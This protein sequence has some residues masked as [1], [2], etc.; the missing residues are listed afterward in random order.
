MNMEATNNAFPTPAP[1]IDL[2]PDS[3]RD[4][5]GNVHGGV[6]DDH[7]PVSITRADAG[8]DHGPGYIADGGTT[9]NSMPRLS[10]T[11]DI[12]AP[13]WDMEG[14]WITIM[15]NGVEVGRVQ[16]DYF[17][18]WSYQPDTALSLGEHHF[19]A[20]LTDYPA[21][22]GESPESDSY[23]LN[24]QSAPAAATSSVLEAGEQHASAPQATFGFYVTG[25]NGILFGG[26]TISSLH[27]AVRGIGEPGSWVT[28]MDGSQEV[29][30][31][32]VGADGRWA[33]SVDLGEGAHHLSAVAST[34]ETS[35]A[36]D[37]N[38]NLSLKVMAIGDDFG[39]THAHGYQIA[40]GTHVT[41][42]LHYS[43]QALFGRTHAD[44]QVVVKDGDRV[45]GTVQADHDGRWNLEY[46][47]D[48]VTGVHHLSAE[49]VGTSEAF[50]F[51]V[52]YSPATT[53]Q[54][55]TQPLALNDV[56]SGS[57]GELFAADPTDNNAT[58]HL[59][60]VHAAPADSMATS[61]VSI[62]LH[63]AS[64]LNTHLVLPHDHVH[65]VM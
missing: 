1:A 47:M 35:A 54:S 45:L 44:G 38:T 11:V 8:Q 3:A 61:G 21:G 34:G 25:E 13:G 22:L 9:D 48:P 58:L 64:S 39:G 57:E 7:G 62:A 60:D 32:R 28:I 31:V 12:Q 49:V 10:G 20:K 23:D 42:P 30:K 18:D 17:G 14:R 59:H 19:S 2:T 63:D 33:T 26:E 55:N 5:Q 16:A 36:V 46:D 6:F 4:T 24:V 53:Q 41:Y 40:D 52:S 29:G 56:L 65:A 50:H 43:H 27:P 51:D 37:F 15:D